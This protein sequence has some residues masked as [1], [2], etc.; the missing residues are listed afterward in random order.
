M[1][2][3]KSL[4]VHLI[5]KITYNTF[6]RSRLTLIGK[7]TTPTKY[8]ILINLDGQIRQN[9]LLGINNLWN[10]ILLMYPASSVPS[11]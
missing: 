10:Y 8:K 4:S 2:Q 9:I 11:G 6:E 3:Q 5:P 1:F 7:N